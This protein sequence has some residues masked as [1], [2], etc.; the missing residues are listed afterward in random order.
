MVAQ[1]GHELLLSSILL[2]QPG[3]VGMSHHTLHL[4]FPS[5]VRYLF[6]SGEA[7]GRLFFR[8]IEFRQTLNSSSYGVGLVGAEITVVYYPGPAGDF[9]FFFKQG[10][11]V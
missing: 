3:I 2:L 7:F 5:A 1:A 9:F 8:E 11:T 10:L 4:L 6:L